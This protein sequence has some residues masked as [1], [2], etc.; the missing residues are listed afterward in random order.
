V[1]GVSERPDRVALVAGLAVALLGLALLLAALGEWD[2]G[3]GGFA[4]LV[5][6][7]AGATLLA[8]GLSRRV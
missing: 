5:L 8:S 1:R 6:A 2:P 3:F 7:A 4:P